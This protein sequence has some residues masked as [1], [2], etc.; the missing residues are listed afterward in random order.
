MGCIIRFSS[1]VCVPPLPKR[2]CA[3]CS[4]YSS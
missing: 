1:A 2:T 3:H 4:K